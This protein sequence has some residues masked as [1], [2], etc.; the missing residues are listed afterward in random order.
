MIILGLNS[1]SR[2]RAGKCGI[3]ECETV[4]DRE[5][6]WDAFRSPLIFLVLN[7]SLSDSHVRAAVVIESLSDTDTPQASR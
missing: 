2:R 1:G 7:V 5:T 3:S 6:I 4:W